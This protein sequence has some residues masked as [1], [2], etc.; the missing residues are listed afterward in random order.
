MILPGTEPVR[1]AG[2]LFGGAALP[3]VVRVAAHACGEHWLTDEE[4]RR[5]GSAMRRA[6]P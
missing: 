4:T 6:W 1:V 3:G 5:E 2:C